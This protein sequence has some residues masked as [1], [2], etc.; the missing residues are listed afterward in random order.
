[1]S[2]STATTTTTPGSERSVVGSTGRRHCAAPW[3]TWAG[4]RT[5]ASE[6]PERATEHEQPSR[7]GH[8]PSG[9]LAGGGGLPPS[10]APPG[11]DRC[12]D[13]VAT[14]DGDPGLRRP[15]A[16]VARSRHELHGPTRLLRG[17]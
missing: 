17:R 3:M 7:I 6:R 10:A 13:L 1:S 5:T 12:P 9:L 4:A 16:Q 15:G 14:A 8:L 2:S 11:V